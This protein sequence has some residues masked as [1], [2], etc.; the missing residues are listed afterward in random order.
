MAEKATPKP[1]TSELDTDTFELMPHKDIVELKEELRQLK[2]KPT[3][4]NL[5]ISIVELS[6]KLDRLIQ[7]FDEAQE[8]LR[9]EEGAGLSWQEKM[10]PLLER[11][12]KILEQNSEIARGLV[13]VAD[14]V[15]ELKDQVGKV[16]TAPSASSPFDMSTNQYIE[17]FE[18]PPAS[19]M[20]P[21]L[22]PLGPA[23]SPPGRLPPLGPAP[24]A[25]GYPLPPPPRRK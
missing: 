21:N 12:D 22:P 24:V 23:P 2:A 16:K 15:N 19:P 10:K 6:T 5:Q 7:I 20:A 18:G 9:V 3:E 13:G 11:M 1:D 17:P 14:E 8:Q 25:P 4:K